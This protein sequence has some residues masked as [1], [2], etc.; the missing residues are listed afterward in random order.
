MDDRGR[1]QERAREATEKALGEIL[2]D[3]DPLGSLS[4]AAACARAW[5]GELPAG[6]EADLDFSYAEPT[7]ICPPDLLARGG[8]RGGCPVHGLT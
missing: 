7:C 2:D 6:E 5:Q 3:E 8:H 1:W 4:L